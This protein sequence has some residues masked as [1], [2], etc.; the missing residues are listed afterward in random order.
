[1]EF[2]HF[3][4]QGNAAMVDVGG[5]PVT[6]RQA[7]ARGRI[8][9]SRECY[10]KVRASTVAKGDVLGVARIA[11]IMATKRTADLIPLCHPLP[12]ERATVD[13]SLDDERHE[14][15]ARCT[16][17]TTGITGV[18]MEALTGVSV[19]LLTVYDMCKAVDKGMEI[20][21]I[22]LLEKAGGKSGTWK[23]DPE[24]DSD[25]KKR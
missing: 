2:T 10:E 9:M 15:E 14:V 25:Q 16:V 24:S 11:G 18:E 13:F 1:M 4:K 21:G 20:H 19:A 23:R 3:D 22:C 8:R 5:K 12:V 6:V 7:I 17:K